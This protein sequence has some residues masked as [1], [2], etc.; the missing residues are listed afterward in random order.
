LKTA[1]EEIGSHRGMLYDA[2]AVDACLRLFSR[3]G[4]KQSVWH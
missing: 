2:D 4:F 3:K 1:L